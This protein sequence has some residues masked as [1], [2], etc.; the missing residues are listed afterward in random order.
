V[1]SAQSTD[2]SVNKVMKNNSELLDTPEK[3]LQLGISNLESLFKSLNIYRNKAKYVYQIA[4]SLVESH[5]SKVP[6][7][8]EQL[9]KLPGVGQKTANVI[10]NVLTNASTIA[11]DTHVMRVSKR[12]GLIS[13]SITSPEKA[14]EALYENVPK[15]YWG[16][17]NHWLVLHGRYICKAKKP[18]CE[19]CSLNTICQAYTPS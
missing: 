13:A 1:L 12:L 16:R 2:V 17:V 3:V 9:V 14:E 10:L 5:D 18:K 4:K 7:C 19:S 6:L 8:F 11:V 15:K